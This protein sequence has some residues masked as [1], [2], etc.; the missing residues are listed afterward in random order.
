MCSHLDDKLRQRGL[1][2][3]SKICKAQG[4]VPVSYIL[5]QELIRVGTVHCHGGFSDVT[6]GEYLGFPV[7]IKRL[8]MCEDFDGI[9]KVSTTNPACYRCST[10]P[11]RLCREIIAWKHLS[12]PNILPLLGIS[13]SQ[14]PLCFHILSEWMSNGN[15]MQ[16]A[17]SNP[18]ANRLR[19]VGPPAF[20]RD[21]PSYSSVT[22]SSLR[23]CLVWPTSTDSGSF[24]GISKA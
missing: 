9:F 3:L 1:R 21:L 5:R 18:G 22:L 6:N 19:L 11:Q 12:H 13:M 24:M 15:V 20:R 4:I 8:R 14:D 2:L 17:R 10:F 16:Y 23:P 7:A